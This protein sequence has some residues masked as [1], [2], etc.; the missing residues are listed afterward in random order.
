VTIATRLRPPLPT[1]TEAAAPLPPVFVVAAEPAVR[2]RLEAL[3][4]AGGAVVGGVAAALAELPV[5][6]GEPAVI[7]AVVADS[8]DLRSCPRGA[9]LVLVG[10]SRSAPPVVLPVSSAVHA[11]LPAD[12]DADEL[13][14]A[15]QVA[16]GGGLY[17]SAAVLDRTAGKALDRLTDREAQTLRLIADGLT[18]RQIARRMGLTETTV[19]TY[20]KRIRRKL[21]AGN[22]AEM[23]RRAL[24][25]GL[26]GG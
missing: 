11:I 26:T 14:L 2:H 1:V 17:V 21:G 10:R 23:T 12:P 4:R 8:G 19:S 7:V 3:V 25:M 16:A 22:K 13:R 5:A 15:V 24:E 9:S 18:H 20:A 6:D